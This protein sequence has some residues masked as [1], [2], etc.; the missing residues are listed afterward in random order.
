M[1]IELAR[2]NL[3][4]QQIRPWDVLDP[5]VLD[6][7]SRI[8][9]EDFVPEAQRSL[10]FMDTEIP[11]PEGESMLAPRVEARLIQELRLQP[12][13][14]VLEV[15]TGSGFMAGLMGL[16]CASVVTVERHASLASLARAHLSKAR[17]GNVSVVDGVVAG[18][19]ESA[20]LSGAFDAILLSGSIADAPQAL[21]KALNPGGRLVAVV[22]SAP[23]MRAVR[24]TR[25]GE[26]AFERVELFDTVAPR[27]VGFPEPS[28]FVF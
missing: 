11:L 2:F 3:I 22:G 1:D 19:L 6:A 20:K 25:T 18:S 15:G 28:R 13:D 14:R 12:G 17:A 24:W 10:A 4:E 27:L 5:L 21:L 16:L 9:R 26:N 7:L 8:R 23:I